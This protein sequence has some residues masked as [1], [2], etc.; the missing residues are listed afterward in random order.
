MLG[1][2]R[3]APVLMTEKDAVKYADSAGPQWWYV[4]LE[5]E[6]EPESAKALL[7]LVLA[8]T[9]LVADGGARG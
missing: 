6:F 3:E 5:V 4:E 7:E 8:R 2:L 1:G 9:G